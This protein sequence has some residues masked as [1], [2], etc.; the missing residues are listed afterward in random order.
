MKAG[1]RRELRFN[2]EPFLGKVFILCGFL[3][4]KQFRGGKKQHGN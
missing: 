3:K 2:E 4:R 1:E